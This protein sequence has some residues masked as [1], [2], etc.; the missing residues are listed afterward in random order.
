MVDEREKEVSW[1]DFGFK[2]QVLK[3]FEIRETRSFRENFES[4]E[5]IGRPLDCYSGYS[6]DF[7]GIVGLKEILEKDLT[8]FRTQS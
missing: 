3:V 4:G 2:E 1:R 5:R 8:R 7:S 6:L